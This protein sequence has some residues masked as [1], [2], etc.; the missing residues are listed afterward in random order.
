MLELEMGI[1]ME[2]EMEIAVKRT[3]AKPYG[4]CVL[5]SSKVGTIV[6]T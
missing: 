3:A 6:R 5:L 2:I 4:V 1:G